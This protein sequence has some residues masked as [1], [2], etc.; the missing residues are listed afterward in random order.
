MKAKLLNLIP[1]ICVLVLALLSWYF[2]MRNADVLYMQQMRSFFNDTPDFFLQY[3]NRPAGFLQWAG[4][5]FTQLF[6][7]PAL[8]SSVLFLMWT[9][10]FLFLKKGLQ[11][12]NALSSVLLVPVVCLLVS[13]IDLYYWIYYNRNAGY[14]FAPTL[15]LLA[16][17]ILTFIYRNIVKLPEKYKTISL[18]VF[19]LFIAVLYHFIGIYSLVALVVVAVIMALERKWK[20]C[21][22]HLLIAIATPLLCTQLYDNLRITQLFTAGLPVFEYGQAT[23]RSLTSPFIT[24]MCSL[25]ILTFINKIG[26]KIKNE[27]KSLIIS[28]LLLAFVIGC[29]INAL[30]KADCDD[31]NYHAECKAYRAIDECKWEDALNYINE[32][33]GTLT[34]QLIIFKNIAL[35]NKGRIGYDMYN[36]DD[37]GKRPVTGDDLSVSMANTASPLIYLHHGMANF[38]YRYCM[39]IQ[40]EFGFNITNLKIMALS[41]IISGERQLAEKYLKLL[42]HTMYYKK[43]AEN[44]LPLAHNPKLIKKYPELAKI[45]ELHSCLPDIATNDNGICENFIVDFFANL[46]NN[47]SAY[48]QE[49]SL[50]YSIISRDIQTFWP[51]Y[52]QYL[53][54]HENEEIPEIYQQAAY[55]YAVNKPD[56]APD[57][58]ESNLR[59]DNA[60]V[61]KY[62][63]FNQEIINLVNNGFSEETVGQ[64][65]KEEY[66]NTFWWTYFYNQDIMCY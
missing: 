62:N 63:L 59:L 50:V 51:H 45:K 24:A 64:M 27:K 33:K 32:V 10:I 21:L 48:L 11:I 42:S 22:Y 16:T 53:R 6:Y 44:Y 9:A 5:F 28:S 40:V 30:C 7:Y 56:M 41:S 15:G 25:I 18:F 57:P 2:L 37:K 52:L 60:V 58:R 4:C 31:E 49:M 35:F 66:G 13:E 39:E 43:W 1:Y 17:S 26:K 34:R 65:T 3:H 36:F 14:C 19:P 55:F 8:G 23:N 46:Q 38:A 20:F 54:L 61:N 12:S 29:S 47:D